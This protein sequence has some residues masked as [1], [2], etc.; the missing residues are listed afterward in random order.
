MRPWSLDPDP[1]LCLLSL[2]EGP[3]EPE[4]GYESV[5]VGVGGRW[6]ASKKGRLSRWREEQD[7][8]HGGW[9]AGAGWW[10][11]R[12][13]PTWTW[14]GAAWWGAV[15]VQAG[16]GSGPWLHVGSSDGGQACA[17]ARKEAANPNDVT[18]RNKAKSS[19]SSCHYFQDIL[20]NTQNFLKPLRMH[21]AFHAL[22]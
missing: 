17:I 11:G 21:F 20:F 4:R 19:L 5:W 13:W 14:V 3:Y 18:C 22:S 1:G 10:W 16:C 2:E 7:E 9:E 15:G 8:W 6:R 12:S